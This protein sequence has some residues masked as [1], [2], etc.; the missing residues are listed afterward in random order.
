MS[1]ADL[2]ERLRFSMIFRRRPRGNNPT[3]V[4]LWRAPVVELEGAVVVQ[5]RLVDE[6]SDPGSVSQRNRWWSA[7]RERGPST[8][9]WW[10]GSLRLLE[11]RMHVGNSGSFCE[12]VKRDVCRQRF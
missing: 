5:C 10:I 1:V 9:F 3:L 7:E 8:L 4:F 11:M 2:W 6:L 12:R